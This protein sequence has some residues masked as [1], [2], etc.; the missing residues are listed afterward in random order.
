MAKRRQSWYLGTLA[1]AKAESGNFKEAIKWQKKVI[2]LV[3]DNK[4]LTEKARQQL[5]L[6]EED[7]PYRE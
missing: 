7:K 5:K 1:A 2:E 4:E 6:Y 3:L